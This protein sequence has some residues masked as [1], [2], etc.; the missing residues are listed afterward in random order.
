MCLRGNCVFT[1]GTKRSIRAQATPLACF[2]LVVLALIASPVFAWGSQTADINLNAAN[3]EF[4]IPFSVNNM[5]PDDSS[6]LEAAIDVEHSD[7]VNVV[8]TTQIESETRGLADV[9]QLSIVDKTTGSE[10]YTGPLAE[11]S[12]GKALEVQLAPQADGVSEL[13]WALT[14]SAPSSMGNEY[15]DASCTA[16]FDWAVSYDGATPAPGPDEPGVT[17]G[18]GGGILDNLPATGDM[19]LM[20]A[21]VLFCIGAAV[22]TRAAAGDREFA[23]GGGRSQRSEDAEHALA[24]GT[25]VAAAE[26]GEAPDPQDEAAEGPFP[27]LDRVRSWLRGHRRLVAAVMAIAC[28]VLAAITAW[29]LFWSHATIPNNRFRMGTVAVDLNDGRSILPDEGVYLEPG[30]TVAEDFTVSNVGSAACYYRLH[31]DNLEGGLAPALHVK[32]ARAGSG[33]VLYEG[34]AVGLELGDACVTADPLEPGATDVLTIQVSMVESAG[35][36]YQ[37]AD[38]TFDVTL[39]A[40]Q[41]KNNEGREF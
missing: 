17:P 2:L 25:A 22:C 41:V 18:T 6:T 40:T 24:L 23:F 27:A 34:S 26:G 14:V 4:N 12:A 13:V 38:V 31:I 11:L 5:L 3:P 30:R 20:L 19:L 10:L 36:E 8:F 21:L 37:G 39:D 33:E 15:Q 1:L 7:P 16:L 9:L 35:N 28:M 32:I 29:A